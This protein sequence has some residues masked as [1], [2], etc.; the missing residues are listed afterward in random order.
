VTGGWKKLH[1]EELHNLFSSPSKIRMIK[2]R[3]MKYVGHV[4][5]KGEDEYIEHFGG[6]TRR[7]DV[8]RNISM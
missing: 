4:A 7:K 6:K 2:S 8:T 1:N 3:R 5:R